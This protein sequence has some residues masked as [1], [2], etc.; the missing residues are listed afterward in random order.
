MKTHIPSKENPVPHAGITHGTVLRKVEIQ[1]LGIW[2][3]AVRV[4]STGSHFVDQFI[5]YPSHSAAI[6]KETGL[7]LIFQF[8]YDNVQKLKDLTNAK[9]F[10]F[11]QIRSLAGFAEFFAKPHQELKSSCGQSSVPSGK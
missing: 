11:L 10:Q 9:L 7:V 4:L 6:K 1:S 2:S 5:C 3:V 8:C